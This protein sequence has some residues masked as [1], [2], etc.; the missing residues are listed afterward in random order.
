[1][2]LVM[3]KTSITDRNDVIQVLRNLHH[4]YLCAI[5]CC[6]EFNGCSDTA[7]CLHNAVLMIR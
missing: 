6:L 3:R 4:V 7:L 5:H 1:M 2:S